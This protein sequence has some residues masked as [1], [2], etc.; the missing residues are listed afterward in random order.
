MERRRVGLGAWIL[1]PRR[2]LVA[3]DRL[4]GRRLGW[5]GV[6]VVHAAGD[7]G[8][9]VAED[10]VRGGL[11]DQVAALVGRRAVTDDVADADV[12]LTGERG[13]RVKCADK[14]G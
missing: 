4:R 8:V 7:S 6:R 9:V 2:A 11:A 14:I 13:A 5:F 10:R 12:N 1:R 3:D